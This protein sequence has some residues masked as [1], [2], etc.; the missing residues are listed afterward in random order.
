MSINKQDLSD[1]A[2]KGYNRVPL[3][4]EVLAD[5][6]T[7]VST[8]L[9]LGAGPY[10]YLFESVQAARHVLSNHLDQA[11]IHRAIGRQIQKLS[12]GRFQT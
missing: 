7:P 12:A 8:Y 11:A 5:L 2:A 9:K 1:Y 4:R 3:M 10:S 6:D